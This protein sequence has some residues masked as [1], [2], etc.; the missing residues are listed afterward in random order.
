[1][2]INLVGTDDRPGR[3]KGGPYPI[4][5]GWMNFFGQMLEGKWS[6]GLNIPKFVTLSI[7]GESVVVDI[8]GPE[9]YACR[10]DGA[11]Q[12]FLV[13]CGNCIDNATH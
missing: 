5:V 1:M 2:E 6:V 4:P 12:L 11:P 13:P 8:P 9:R 10:L 7:H 3:H